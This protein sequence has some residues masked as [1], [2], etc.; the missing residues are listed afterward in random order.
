MQ[1]PD[2]L[3]EPNGHFLFAVVCGSAVLNMAIITSTAAVAEALPIDHGAVKLMTQYNRYYQYGFLLRC[4]L[5]AL[6][7]FPLPLTVATL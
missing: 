1:P 2:A 5:L 6:S 3:L 4:L 7:H